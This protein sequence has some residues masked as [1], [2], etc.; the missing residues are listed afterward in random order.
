MSVIPIY[1]LGGNYTSYVYNSGQWVDGEKTKELE[2]KLKE[3]LHVPYIVLTNNGTS[4]LLAAYFVLKSKY[5]NLI[6]DP[7]TFPATYQ[8]ARMLNYTVNF[9]RFISRNNNKKVVFSPGT[10]LMTVTHLFGQPNYLLAYVKA[11]DYIEDACQAFGAKYKGKFVGTFGKIGCFSF[12]PTK[13]LHTCGHAGAVITSDE[14]YYQQMKIFIES[15]RKN[16][17]MTDSVAL[18]L[19]IDEIKAE[20]LLNELKE[21]DKRISIQRDIAHEFKKYISGYQP[22]LEEESSMYHT[23]S[24]FNLL[25]STRDKFRTYMDKLGIQTLIYYSEEILPKDQRYSYKDMTSTI[26]AI[27]CRWNLTPIEI[28]RITNALQGWFQ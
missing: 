11:A 21:F 1:K 7:Y 15:G 9:R 16:G 2:E 12:Y 4:A 20:Y 17:I 8:T 18:N 14:H 13:L 23:Y 25:I 10:S 6:V 3:Y 24:I 22:F 5:K 27:P 26:V 28:R 19:R